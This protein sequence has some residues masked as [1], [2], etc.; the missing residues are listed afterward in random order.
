MRTL[1]CT[2]RTLQGLACCWVIGAG[3]AWGATGLAGGPPS[4]SS[5]EPGASRSVLWN[6]KEGSR[7]SVGVAVGQQQLPAGQVW[8]PNPMTGSA[9]SGAQSA[10]AASMVLGMGLTAPRPQGGSAA[11]LVWQAPLTTNQ[12]GTAAVSAPN[13]ATVDA[14]GVPQPMRMGLVLTPADPLAELRGGAITKV[15]LSGHMALSL[16]PR[17]GGVWLSLN[18]KW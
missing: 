18:G 8:S 17:A 15:Q 2:R 12:P 11:R 13:A 4:L 14:S 1:P 9:I 5:A 6:Q 10:G 16:R 7:W 3:A